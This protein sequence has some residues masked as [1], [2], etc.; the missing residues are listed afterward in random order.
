MSP[1]RK[2]TNKDGD[3]KT[4]PTNP[5]TSGDKPTHPTKTTA[6]KKRKLK[7]PV[8]EEDWG[9]NTNPSK[10]RSPTN[11]TQTSTNQ[12]TEVLTMEDDQNVKEDDR[13]ETQ[14]EE[15]DLTRKM[16]YQGR[17][18]YKRLVTQTTLDPGIDH[19]GGAGLVT[20]IP[21]ESQEIPD[22]QSS[23]IERTELGNK[24]Q[25]RAKDGTVTNGSGDNKEGI[26]VELPKPSGIT[27]KGKLLPRQQISGRKLVKKST[28][29]EEKT[30]PGRGRKKSKT[31][32]PSGQ[33]TQYY[34]KK[35]ADEEEEKR[36][37]FVRKEEGKIKESIRMFSEL[38]EG[39]DCVIGSGMYS[40]H[41]AK[42]K[43]IVKK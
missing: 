36:T 2:R 8:L 9:M 3:H 27:V 29:V 10:G 14:G 5:T 7:Y 13:K 12:E 17:S 42:L 32:P 28:P 39:E 26:T 21:P 37:T 6:T 40:R 23:S 43:K 4:N 16:A 24:G 19:Q 33:I 15:D 18:P 20:T 31:V 22:G 41:N 1:S 11:Q 35:A 25:A 30:T 34:K 38:K